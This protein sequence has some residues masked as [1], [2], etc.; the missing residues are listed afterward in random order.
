M[1]CRNIICEEGPV[2]GVRGTIVGFSWLDSNI[3]QPHKGALPQNVYV[4]F[5]IL[6]LVS[7]AR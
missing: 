7:S 2:N 6:V 1:L 5:M 4:N 3:S